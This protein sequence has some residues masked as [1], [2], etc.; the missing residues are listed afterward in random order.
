VALAEAVTAGDGQDLVAA[1]SRRDAVRNHL[2]AAQPT[3]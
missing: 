3:E 2:Y 1:A